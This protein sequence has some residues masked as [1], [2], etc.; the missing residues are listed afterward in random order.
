M[1]GHSSI[2]P[3][4]FS[5]EEEGC[6]KMISTYKELQ[7][8]LGAGRHL[9]VEEQDTAYDAIKKEWASILSNV[10]LQKQR[11]FPSMQAGYKGVLD[12]QEAVER[13]SKS[14]AGCLK[15]FETT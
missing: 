6:V 11:T 1:A 9:F 7:H 13:P 8:H 2:S 5:C 3:G 15:T 12:R 14:E 10:C 4:L